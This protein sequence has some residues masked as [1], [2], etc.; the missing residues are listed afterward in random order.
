ML[1]APQ[2]VA[3]D[4]VSTHR[5]LQVVFAQVEEH[6]ELLQKGA[7]LGQMVPHAPQFVALDLVSTHVP[8]HVV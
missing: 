2:L 5:P 1:H 7:V 8:L 3:S 4:L 6:T